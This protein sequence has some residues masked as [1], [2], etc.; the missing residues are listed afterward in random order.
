MSWEGGK[1]LLQSPPPF[2]FDRYRQLWKDPPKESNKPRGRA[3]ASGPLISF[4]PARR[5]EARSSQNFSKPPWR[6]PLVCLSPPPSPNLKLVVPGAPRDHLPRGTR[7]GE[8]GQSGCSCPEVQD[9]D[10]TGA[11]R[12]GEW[13]PDAQPTS[14]VREVAKAL[15]EERDLS[16]AASSSSTTTTDQFM[17]GSAFE[18]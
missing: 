8:A 6:L 7:E 11:W 5:T 15:G 10:T 13:I 17:F 12:N 9:R 18:I 2:F 4:S 16:V 14:Q 3:R 1:L